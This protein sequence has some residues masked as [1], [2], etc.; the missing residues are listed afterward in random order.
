MAEYL[1]KIPYICDVY[2]KEAPIDWASMNPK[3]YRAILKASGKFSD[4]V[5]RQDH[6]VENYVVQCKDLGIRYG[7]YHFLRQ[8]SITE[9]AQLF[10]EVWT[11]VGGADMPPI[12][13]VEIELP[14]PK[15]KKDKKFTGEDWAYQ[16]KVWL[17]LVEN[18]S[19]QKPI[20]YTSQKYWLETFDRYGNPPT[21]T[22]EYPLW[23][24][25]Y[26]DKEFVDANNVPAKSLIPAGWTKWALWQ[27]SDTGIEDGYLAN[28]LNTISSEFAADLDARYPL[29]A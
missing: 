16:I 20:I 4:G 2:E 12:V 5:R 3:P 1:L 25:W 22:D 18:W 8:D 27:Y 29:N 24:A 11:K 13:D 9:Q 15:K 7:L 23:V 6:E 26:P 28:D 14:K 10:W 21:W 17:S 19:G